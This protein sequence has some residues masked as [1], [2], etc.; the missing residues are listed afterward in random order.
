MFWPK[1]FGGVSVG[2]A[3]LQCHFQ[4]SGGIN[5]SC[6]APRMEKKHRQ[7]Y[8]DMIMDKDDDESD[9]TVRI[10]MFDYE[11]DM[12]NEDIMEDRDEELDYG[13]E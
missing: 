6:A 2:V 5:L 1:T 10:D 11:L 12:H 7:D 9:D 3:V 4:N 8:E 13:D